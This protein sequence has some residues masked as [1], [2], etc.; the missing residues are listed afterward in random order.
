MKV[1]IRYKIVLPFL[2]LFIL[3]FLFGYWHLAKTLSK[4]IEEQIGTQMREIVYSIG[5]TNYLRNQKI[6]EKVKALI[7]A[8]LILGE[9][10]NRILSST[11]SVEETNQ[12]LLWIREKNIF[13]VTP[14]IDP[15]SW[16]ESSLIFREFRLPSGLYS[17]FATFLPEKR[18][19]PCWMLL[20]FS[21][22]R[23]LAPQQKISRTLQY[24]LYPA[25]ILIIGIGFLISLTITR[26]LEGLSSEAKQIAHGDWE[27][28]LTVQ[29]SDEVGELAQSFNLMLQELRHTQSE[30]LQAEKLATLGKIT[31]RV[32][33][34]IRNP[35]TSIRMILQNAKRRIEQQQ[36]PSSESFSLVMDE[37]DRLEWIIQELLSFGPNPPE[38]K[39]AWIPLY[40]LL[41]GMLSI[42]LTRFTHL[43]IKLQKEY[44]PR[45]TTVYG[46]GDKI[47]QVFLNLLLN[48]TQ[49]MPNG[50]E[51][52]VKTQLQ[53]S[54]SIEITVCDTGMGVSPEA[55]A[56]LF[57][58]FFTTRS[59]GTGLGLST[60]REIVKQHQGEMGY[61]RK[62]PGS[63]FWF[64]LPHGNDEIF[65]QNAE[66]KLHPP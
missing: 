17:I 40:P 8:D 34:E 31:A 50:G 60:S 48:A 38:L 65:F 54:G 20:F 15:K 35:L 9:Q 53:F 39:Q 63:E 42:A 18:N 66:K 23:F 13:A 10:F 21:E 14:E 19:P 62:N 5:H 22:E 16:P 32:A 36:F 24:A 59:N 44:D 64:T 11:L 46:D 1:R 27:K 6:V 52:K 30:L 37:I 43:K 2:C 47:K 3:V 4:Q 12:V 55:E 49:A 56:H 51:L 57:K 45:I 33:H 25:L 29:T 58:S 28:N 26:P 41:D 7:H 61:R